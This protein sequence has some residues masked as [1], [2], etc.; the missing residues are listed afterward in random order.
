MGGLA[1]QG[2]RASM[3]WMTQ[4]ISRPTN[5]PTNQRDTGGVCS[6][7]CCCWRLLLMCVQLPALPPFACPPASAG[8]D[9]QLW[10][11]VLEYFSSLEDASSE[12][13]GPRAPWGAR[14]RLVHTFTTFVTL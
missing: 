9:P 10:H 3:Q 1:M 4:S 12:Q 13:V 8:G 5:Q 6:C 14:K 7:R 11:D 2:A